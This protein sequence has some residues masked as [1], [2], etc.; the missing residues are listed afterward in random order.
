M[1]LL[2]GRVA[3]VTG[4]SSGI[5]RATAHHLASLGAHVVVNSAT[6]IEAGEQVAN[7]LETPSV[8]LQGDITDPGDRERL[9]TATLESYGRLDILINNAGWTSF[10]EHG[11]LAGLTE[12]IFRRTFEV[13]VFGT[14]SLTRLAMPHLEASS[15]G[16]VVTI[17]SV[18]GIRPAGSSIAYSM[19]KA[20]L[21]HMTR[22]LAKSFGPVRVNAVAPGLIE[23]PWTSGWDD[24]HRLVAQRA[25]AQRSGKSDEVARAVGSL[26]TNGYV[27]GAVLVV[28]GGLS[29]VL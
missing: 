3:I 6:S 13:N 17:T 5:G 8:Y 18:A 26:V 25:P 23:T 22:L 28:D 2:Q 20:S 19:S 10:I 1:S 14:W 7:E 9:I 29:Q 24:M 27:T 12:D 4:S 15:D 21:N 16:N 11:D